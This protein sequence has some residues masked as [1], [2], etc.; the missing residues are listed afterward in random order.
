MPY[1][2]RDISLFSGER[3]S[4]IVIGRNVYCI[5][6]YGKLSFFDVD[7]KEVV[8]VVSNDRRTLFLC[9]DKSLYY[10]G[11]APYFTQEMSND[12]SNTPSKLAHRYFDKS[13]IVDI[14][15]Y[16]DEGF[17]VAENGKLYKWGVAP[18]PEWAALRGPSGGNFQ[19][20]KMSANLR[21]SVTDQGVL[22]TWDSQPAV[23]STIVSLP[24][25]DEI[26]TDFAVA[27]EHLLMLTDKGNVYFMGQNAHNLL[28]IESEA[29][30]CLTSPV[31]I[32]FHEKIDHITTHH[33]L[34]AAISQSGQVY[35]WGEGQAREAIHTPLNPL[36]TEHLYYGIS[37][38]DSNVILTTT[39]GCI[40]RA[41]YS[42]DKNITLDKKVNIGFNLAQNNCYD[43]IGFFIKKNIVPIATGS[44]GLIGIILVCSLAGWCLINAAIGL[45]GGLATFALAYLAYTCASCYPSTLPCCVC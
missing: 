2:A 44:A 10:V 25:R 16:G 14:C 33:S 19:C 13:A 5:D 30:A 8:K 39:A 31:K 6:E 35:V 11:Q 4:F 37:I 18:G 40:H 7:G 9:K 12:Y 3:K 1:S 29:K 17:V 38:S 32:N 26:L 20:V 41:P 34:C 28:G 21:A 45:A 36:P 42:R 23:Q 24:E 27:D 15:M 43:Q 22:Q